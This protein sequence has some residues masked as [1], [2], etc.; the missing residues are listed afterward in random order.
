MDFLE[1]DLVLHSFSRNFI[2]LDKNL[3]RT[4]KLIFFTLTLLKLST[5]LITLFFS[6]NLKPMEC[7][8][9]FLIGSLII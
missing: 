7:Q 9:D 4:H 1:T 3:I 6:E 8:V 5:L 2:L